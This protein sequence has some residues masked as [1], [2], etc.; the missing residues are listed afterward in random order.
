MHVRSAT[1][2]KSRFGRN[3]EVPAVTRRDVLRGLMTVPLMGG[4]A[5]V[6]NTP[7]LAQAPES[8]A[9]AGGWTSFRNSHQNRGIAA[10]PLADKLKL[11]WE[12]TTP[13]GTSSTAA[14]ADGRIYMG[15]LSGD[16]HCFELRTGKPVWTYKTLDP[17]PANSFAPGFNAAAALNDKLVLIG[18]D[19]GT[20]HA[21]SRETGKKVWEKKTAGEIVGGAQ[22]IGDQVIFG[23][24]DGHLY[25]CLAE[26]GA[27]LWAVETHGPV[28]ATPCLTQGKTVT[29]GCDQPILRVIDTALGKEAAEIPIR[30]TMLIAAAASYENNLYFGNSDGQVVAINFIDQTWLWTHVPAGQST[31]VKSSPAVT[32]ELVVIGGPDKSLLCLDRKTGEKKWSFAT[33]G[34]VESSPVIAG[35]RVYFGANDKTLYALSL[36]DGAEVWREPAR[37]AVKGSP[38]IAEG[39][40]VIGTSDSNGKILCYGPA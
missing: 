9:P 10:A 39:H 5:A 7:L 40:L 23:S 1:E 32:A 22:V 14:I 29:T 34:Q 27:E 12:V 36:A 31:Q 16:L 11:L 26:T 25:C 38:A 8:P 19:Q 20:F 3:V 37:A 33:R 2:Q 15:T 28:N 21:V 35:N 18:D 6:L 4:L 24:H 30:N 17:V 13:D